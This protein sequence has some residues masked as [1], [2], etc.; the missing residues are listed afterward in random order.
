M[1]EIKNKD[2]NLSQSQSLERFWESDVKLRKL[3]V[4]LV[5][6]AHGSGLSTDVFHKEVLL[7]YNFLNT[8]KYE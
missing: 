5:V 1:S 2:D 3:A 6:M 8:G 7:M 4:E